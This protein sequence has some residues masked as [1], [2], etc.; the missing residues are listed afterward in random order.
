M[1]SLRIR[2]VNMCWVLSVLIRPISQ[3]PATAQVSKH[4][5]DEEFRNA[6]ML[7]PANDFSVLQETIK[8]CVIKMPTLKIDADQVF[9]EW[10][11]RNTTYLEGSW[12]VR[13]EF[14][15]YYK[16]PSTPNI[17]RQRGRD[18]Y[19]IKL[20]KIVENQIKNLLDPIKN[21]IEKGTKEKAEELFIS[22]LNSIIDGRYDLKINDPE[23]C[24]YFERQ[25]KLGRYLKRK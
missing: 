8:Y 3:L 9:D 22:L 15:Q 2:V 1:N 13:L 21:E 10:E 25:R 5:T 14:I 6:A 11:K 19:E 12:Y 7:L 24:D 20:V 23:L 18:Q 16:H 17:I 4:R